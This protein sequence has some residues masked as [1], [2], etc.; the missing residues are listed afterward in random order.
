MDFWLFSG[1]K[2]KVLSPFMCY[3]LKYQRINKTITW[4]IHHLLSKDK[5]NQIK[6]QAFKSNASNAI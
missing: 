6:L 5:K 2:G 3:P 4:H 1:G